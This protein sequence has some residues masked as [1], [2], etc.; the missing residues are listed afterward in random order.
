MEQNDVTVF[1]QSLMVCG[2]PVEIA[3]RVK[4]AFKKMPSDMALT[5]F[6]KIMT[7]DLPH[8]IKVGVWDAVR[9]SHIWWCVDEM[10]KGPVMDNSI[11]QQA[12]GDAVPMR[13]WMVD[14]RKYNWETFA[15]TLDLHTAFSS[16]HTETEL[17][18]LIF[19]FTVPFF[20]RLQFE[21]SRQHVIKYFPIISSRGRE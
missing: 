5:C 1:Q 20:Q 16:P 11:V 6:A 7:A 10:L 13:K 15:M 18:R 21:N 12:F 2:D 4:L 19:L 14:N 3:R 8:N 17:H 9:Y